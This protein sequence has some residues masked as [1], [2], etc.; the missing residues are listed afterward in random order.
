MAKIKF[1][2]S[3][4]PYKHFTIVIYDFRVTLTRNLYTVRLQSCKLGLWI[5]HKTWKL[6]RIPILHLY[7]WTFFASI[8]LNWIIK[9]RSWFTEEFNSMQWFAPQYSS[10]MWLRSIDLLV[11]GS[12]LDHRENVKLVWW[13][14]ERYRHLFEKIDFF[15]SFGILIE[16]SVDLLF[17]FLFLW[18]KFR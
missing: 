10:L 14:L 6:V 13:G 7:F 3:I 11:S 17:L 15:R 16:L 12:K 9:A 5:V 4:E 1:Q 8:A 18:L 2:D